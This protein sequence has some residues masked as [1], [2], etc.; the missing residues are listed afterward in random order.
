MI[1]TVTDLLE[2]LRHKEV[3]LLDKQDITHA[4]TIGR[5]YE[6]L[7]RKILEKTFPEG[8]D[9]RVVSG[10]ITNSRGD[11]S[12]QIDCMLVSGEGERIPY[13]D[14]YKYHIQNVIA[15][16]E[17]KKNLYSSDLDSAYKNLIT[18]LKRG[19]FTKEQAL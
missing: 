4:P 7:T 6:G 10:F 1:S 17:V 11:L 5:M 3:Q 12:K 14:D 18:V 8:L 13:T 9:L 16:V 15:V 19:R 2:A